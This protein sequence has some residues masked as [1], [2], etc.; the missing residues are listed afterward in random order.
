MEPVTATRTL[1]DVPVVVR[2]SRKNAMV[3]PLSIGLVVSGP[4]LAPD[5][6][7]VATDVSVYMDLA[8][9]GTGVLARPARIRLPLELTLVDASPEVFTVTVQ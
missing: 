4:V 1:D 9:A 5:A 2:H 7:D 8:D 6:L 3:T